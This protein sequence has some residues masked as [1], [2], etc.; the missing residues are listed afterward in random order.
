MTDSEFLDYCYA[1]ADTPRCGFVPE[2]AARL[3]RLAGQEDAVDQWGRVPHG[4][5]SLD[6]H[7]VRLAVEM[8]RAQ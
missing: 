6:P 5:Y 8:A 4:V 3:A 2:H 7:A 1:H